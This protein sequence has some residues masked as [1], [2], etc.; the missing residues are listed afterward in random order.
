MKQPRALVMYF[1]SFCTFAKYL[2]EISL[3]SA[4]LLGYPVLSGKIPTSI[5]YKSEI[6]PQ[7]EDSLGRAVTAEAPIHQ[8]REPLMGSAALSR[9]V[10]GV[11]C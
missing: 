8:E 1:N 9:L 4:W 2:R 5:A 7:T 3:K 6:F 10:G 11:A